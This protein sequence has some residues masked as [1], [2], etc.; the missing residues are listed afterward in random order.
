MG[1]VPS[2]RESKRA[3]IGL[4]GC[5]HEG[6]KLGIEACRILPERSMADV[7]VQRELGSAIFAAG[8]PIKGTH[9]PSGW[10]GAHLAYGGCAREGK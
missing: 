1:F 6:G 4:V 9:S 3:S 8:T 5:P 2:L 7:V 10:Y